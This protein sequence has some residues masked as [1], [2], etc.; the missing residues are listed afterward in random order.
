MIDVAVTSAERTWSGSGYREIARPGL[1]PECRF[2]ITGEILIAIGPRLTWSEKL[3][4]AARS[5]GETSRNQPA[6]YARQGAKLWGLRIREITMQAIT[7]SRPA[8]TW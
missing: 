6:P 3:E 8:P 1:R 2:E 5:A 4:P 7:M